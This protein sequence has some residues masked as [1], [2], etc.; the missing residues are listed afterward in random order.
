MKYTI[1]ENKR[2]GEKYYK[3]RHKSGLKIIVCPKK[4]FTSSYALIGTKFGSIN[5]EFINNGRKIKVPDGTAH[6]LEHKL[7]ES[8]E[9][10]AFKLYA[11]TG[12]SANAY[13]SFDTTCYLF[14][15]TDNF[16]ES[17]GILFDLIQSPYFTPE[18]IEKEQGIIG[19]EIKMYQDSPEWMV[20]MNLL[21]ALY[22]NHPINIDIAGTVDTIAEITPDTLYDCYNSYYNLN[23]MVLCVSGNVSLDDVMEVA[24]SKLKDNEP[25]VTESIFPDEPYEV[26][27]SF[28]EQKLPIAVPL[29]A[30]GF[31]E[32]APKSFASSKELLCTS[33]LLKA[34]AGQSSALYRRLLDE[35]LVNANFGTEYMEGC[36]YR[37]VIFSGESREPEKAADIIKEEVVRLHETGISKEDFEIAKRSVYGG[38]AYSFDSNYAIAAEVINAE[39]TGRGIFEDADIIADITLDDI[40]ERLKEQLD[41]NNCSLSVIKGLD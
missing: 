40:N 20:N 4:D 34:F 1:I 32:N 7:F 3:F 29:F 31:K 8:E 41:P 17:L 5:S 13:T 27:Q 9:G 38:I 6:Y 2:F 22:H 35:K 24:D 25:V 18:T 16:K 19:Q 33:I 26:K 23:N 39:F 14:S 10:D 11:K 36:G 12:A 28:T 37:S 30:V 21:Q 15:C